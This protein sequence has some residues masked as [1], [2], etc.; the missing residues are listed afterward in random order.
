MFF[1]YIVMNAIYTLCPLFSFFFFLK[2]P[3]PPELSPF[4]LHD[5][6]PINPI[7]QADAHFHGGK[8]TPPGGVGLGSVGG[9]CLGVDLQ[10]FPQEE[11]AP[12]AIPPDASQ[13]N[14]SEW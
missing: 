9:N 1:K 6:L 7:P 13:T 3:A 10:C 2:D 5:A 12:K 8:G 11:E 4:P 14:L